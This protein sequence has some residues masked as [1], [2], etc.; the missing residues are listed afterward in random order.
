MGIIFCCAVIILF[1]EYKIISVFKLIKKRQQQ[2]CSHDLDVKRQH[3][4][5]QFDFKFG[6]QL[7]SFACFSFVKQN[8][9]MLKKIL[10]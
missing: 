3:S 4:T 8:R 5:N 1:G 2:K 6:I 10:H 7:G 9:T